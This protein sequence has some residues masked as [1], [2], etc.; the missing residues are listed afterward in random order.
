MFGRHLKRQFS[1]FFQKVSQSDDPFIFLKTFFFD[2]GYNSVTKN[3]SYI[4]TALHTSS[5]LL[6]MVY[7]IRHFTLHILLKYSSGLLIMIYVGI[8]DKKFINTEM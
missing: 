7:L 6:E 1:V 4:C 8:L 2:G 3:I 5:Y